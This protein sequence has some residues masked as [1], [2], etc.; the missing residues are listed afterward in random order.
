MWEKKFVMFLFCLVVISFSFV[1]A[2]GANILYIAALDDVTKPSDDALKAYLEG[3]GHTVTYL[4]DDTPKLDMSTAAAAADVVFISESSSSSKVHSKINEIA[5]PMVVSEDWGWN[6]MGLATLTP[7]ATAEGI[8]VATTD[9]EIVAPGHPLAAGLT[10]TVPVLT[11]ITGTGG[12]ARFSTDTPGSKATVIAQAT[13][14]DGRTYDIIFVYEKG[15]ELAQPPA[16]GTPNKAADIRVCFGFEEEW[17]GYLLWNE[18]AFYLLE[19]AINFALG[20]RIQPE[21]YSPKPAN[22]QAEVPRDTALSWRQGIFAEKHNVYF[23]TSIKDVNQASVD[24]PR[25]VLVSP[26]QE[27]TTYEITDLLDYGR[28]YYW[29]VDEVNA[30][31]GSYVYK[32]DVWSFTVANFLVVD[33]F[34]DYDDVNNVIYNTWSD[35]FV[36]N[37]GMTVG[38]FEPPFA[39]QTVVHSGEQSMPLRYDNDGT[40]NEGTDYETAGTLLYSEVERQCASGQD[41]TRDGVTSLSLWHKGYSPYRGG[42]VEQPAGT[43][44]VKAA[45][46]DIWSNADQFHFAYKEV[47]S[48]AHSIIAKVESLDAIYKDSKA[49]IM[50]RDSL[51]PGAKNV[52]LLLTPDATKGL[53]F[54]F[55]QTTDGTT[56][57][58]TT[59]DPNANLDPNAMAPYWLK[60]ERTT[61]GI[62]RAFR[63]PDGKNDT[64]TQFP[65]QVVTMTMPIYIGLAVTS[66]DVTQVCEATFSNVSFPD[67]SISAHWADQD[68]GIVS[69]STEPMYVSVTSGNNTSTVYNDDPNAVNMENWTEWIIPLQTFADDGVNLSSVGKIA[70]GLGTKGTTTPGGSGK[71]YF[72]DIRLYRPPF[73]EE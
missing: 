67:T 59:A 73:A 41:W 2:R 72:D 15:D 63:S 8:E 24:D 42:F 18:N 25:S 30:P 43:Y 6:E 45:G 48:G 37:T 46:A 12:T 36:N 44:K 14:S 34:E 53:R 32:G 7:G 52:T 10:G 11:T 23:G 21:A 9:I 57:R 29:R 33:D 38:Y 35:Y 58:G 19:A 47:A 31:P 60:F 66:H 28:T 13:L 70:I 40:V 1:G 5:T 68:I 22:G 65:I 27:G 39:E 69:N 55:R 3:L 50:I 17:R 56:I 4:D 54:Q 61:G 51:E 62:V 26:E 16:D 64:W 20:I 49:G 71:L